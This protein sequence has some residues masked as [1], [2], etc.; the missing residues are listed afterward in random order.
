MDAWIRE[1]RAHVLPLRLAKGFDVVG[2][3][4]RREENLFVWLVGHDELEDAN[5]AY[6]ASPER[7]MLVPDPTR[8]LA[9]TETWILETLE[10]EVDRE[11]DGDQGEPDK[12][13]RLAP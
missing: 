3:W 7:A 11:P 10:R 13:R 4:V 8:H 1:W 6:Y 12:Q 2:P 9:A 5:D